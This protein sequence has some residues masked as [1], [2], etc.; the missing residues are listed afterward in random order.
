MEKYFILGIVNKNKD[1]VIYETAFNNS[2]NLMSKK[3]ENTIIVHTQYENIE[4]NIGEIKIE[5]NK[6]F[7]EKLNMFVLEALILVKLTPTS[8]GMENCEYTNLDKEKISGAL[9]SLIAKWHYDDRE[10]IDILDLAIDLLIRLCTGHLI[11]N[12]NKRLSM[13]TCSIFLKSVGLYLKWSSYKTYYLKY[14]ENLMIDIA[15]NKYGNDIKEIKENKE[16]NI[17]KLFL[18]SLMISSRWNWK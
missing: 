6:E 2:I 18:T 12:G 11:Q 16:L 15:S 8:Y 4:V 3:D 7:H 10:N 14:W 13:L 9:Y 1:K 5:F 17:R